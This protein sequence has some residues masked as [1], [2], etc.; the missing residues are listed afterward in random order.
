MERPG[1]L[2]ECAYLK[3]KIEEFVCI[4]DSWS[5]TG[6]GNTCLALLITKPYYVPSY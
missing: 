4:I 5:T 3:I 6:R 2:T 1:S